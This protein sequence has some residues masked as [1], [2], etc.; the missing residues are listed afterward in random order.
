LNE[1]LSAL[2]RRGA[3]DSL[4]RGW[5]RL[6]RITRGPVL[7]CQHRASSRR[8][9][10]LDDRVCGSPGLQGRQGLPAPAP[11]LSR[12]SESAAE[13]A[14]SPYRCC[15]R[16][17]GHGSLHVPASGRYR[18]RG[19]DPVDFAAPWPFTAALRDL[20]A[21]RRAPAFEDG[22]LS[23]LDR[24]ACLHFRSGSPDPPDLGAD[25]PDAYR[26]LRPGCKAG[27]P[28]VGL[29]KD[30]P[31]IVQAS[32]SGSRSRP[33][34]RFRFASCFL[35]DGK[36]ASH[37][38]AARVVSHHLDGLFLLDPATV[39]QAAADPGVHRFSFRRETEFPA[40]HLLPFEAFPPPTA[41]VVR[42]ES[43]I[44]VG[45]RHRLDRFRPLRSPRTLPPRPF[46][47]RQSEIA[48]SCSSSR[49]SRGLEAFLRHRVRC[50]SVRFRPSAPGA[51]LGLADCPCPCLR[52]DAANQ[53][54]VEDAPK[55]GFSA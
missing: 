38:R 33:A 55:S 11:L 28:L 23:D 6:Q 45:P 39:F 54:Y 52:A 37:P 41:T 30:R 29:S 35:R 8:R 49:G 40:M 25:Y 32:E 14:N 47:S 36:A 51:P 53:R 48:V 1:P 43:L 17:P 2:L 24:S 26:S 3:R 16:A 44:P 46:L 9:T 10:P 42:D 19:E 20:G 34:L 15:A 21:R 13:A 5:T 12:R 31:S 22:A 7:S 4:T 50:A 27:F 18:L